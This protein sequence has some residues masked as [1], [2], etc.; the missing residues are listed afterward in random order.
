MTDLSTFQGNEGA[1]GELSKGPHKAIRHQN[2]LSKPF[3][4]M[5]SCFD[6]RITVMLALEPDVK[7]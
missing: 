4:L 1:G 7:E 6:S 3:A 2:T 5:L